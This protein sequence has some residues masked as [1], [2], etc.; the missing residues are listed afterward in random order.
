[1]NY[2][3]FLKE[4]TFIY[5]KYLLFFNDRNDGTVQDNLVN[6]F[7]NENKK[8]FLDHSFPTIRLSVTHE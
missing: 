8:I 5:K 3:S 6:G 2:Q 1:M 4:L 7:N